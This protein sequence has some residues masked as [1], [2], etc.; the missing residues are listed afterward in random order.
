M[1]LTECCVKN[2]RYYFYS[3]VGKFSG[4]LFKKLPSLADLPT[5]RLLK[6]VITR[7]PLCASEPSNNI[8]AMP[9]SV[10]FHITVYEL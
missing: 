9:T 10:V 8:E 7:I 5:R 1:C 4:L 6:S 2:N 3:S